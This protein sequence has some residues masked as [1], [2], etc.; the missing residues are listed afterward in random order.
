MHSHDHVDGMTLIEHQLDVPLDHSGRLA[1]TLS[2]FAREVTPAGSE[3][4][5]RPAL[6]FLQGGPGGRA[7]RPRRND[8]WLAAALTAGY[9]VVLLDQRGTGRSAPIDPAD[10]PDADVEHA[11]EHLACFRADAIVRD[12]ELLR[13][14]LLGADGRWTLLGQSFGGF[15]A[16]HY[17]SVAPEALDGVMITGGVPSLERPAIDV[18]RRTFATLA[19]KAARFAAR[20]PAAAATL[21]DV[22][23]YCDANEVALPD[24]SPLRARSVRQLGFQ[25]GTGA[26]ERVLCETL[27]LAFLGHGASRRLSHTFLRSMRALAPFHDTPIF[28]A[29]HEPIYAQGE[30]TAW[31]AQRASAE[32]RDDP[33]ADPSGLDLSAEMVFPWHFDDALPLR[34]WRAV[35]ERLAAKSDWSRLY[36]PAAL[37]RNTVPIAALAYADDLYVP[38][39][40]TRETVATVRRM[41]LWVTNEYEHDGIHVDGRRIVERLLALMRD[42]RA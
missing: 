12:C 26:G 3:R 9:R 33:A 19:H 17:L 10:P 6:L 34:P 7:P 28:A 35:A 14:A 13:Q 11:A 2:L 25:L 22:I 8:G 37:A 5:R 16:M 41:E 24:G 40:W 27:E 38:L 42:A 23:A 15:V 32:R 36:D 20:Q 29:L 4:E 21:R 1:G 39:E 31:A 30:A 18:Y